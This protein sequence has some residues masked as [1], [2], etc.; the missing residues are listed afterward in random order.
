MRRQRTRAEYCAYSREVG[1]R[2]QR[3]RKRQG[4]SQSALALLAGKT[5]RYIKYLERGT[6]GYVDSTVLAALAP[7]LEVPAAD[8]APP[9][10]AR[11][12]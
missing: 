12:S 5:G 8:L 1:Q 2:V 4:L 6:P 3:A 10:S 7:A 9:I 11:R